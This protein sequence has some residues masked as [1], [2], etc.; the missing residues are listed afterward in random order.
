MNRKTELMIGSLLLLVAL[1]SAALAYSFWLLTVNNE[2]RITAYKEI[3]CEYPLGNKIIGFDWGNFSR[4]NP[5]KTET[6]YL[7]SLSNTALNVTWNVVGLDSAF[8]FSLDRYSFNFTEYNQV[9]AFNATL[10]LV[11]YGKAPANF[12]FDLM[13]GEE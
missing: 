1:L 11:D 7:R 3:Q 5:S 12:A 10:T 9:I 13:F 8:T 4:A 2:M 6:F